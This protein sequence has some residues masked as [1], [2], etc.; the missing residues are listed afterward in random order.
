MFLQYKGS[1][2]KNFTIEDKDPKGYFLN[3]VIENTTYDL[4]RIFSDS[5]S[6]LLKLGF[7]I[8]DDCDVLISLTGSNTVVRLSLAMKQEYGFTVDLDFKP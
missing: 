8:K 6:I 5:I 1:D 4:P 7:K 2:F 3:L